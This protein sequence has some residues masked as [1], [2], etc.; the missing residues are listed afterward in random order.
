MR[1]AASDS[2][3]YVVMFQKG[4]SMLKTCF[5]LGLGWTM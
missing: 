3:N 5:Q 4:G 2:K 1:Q